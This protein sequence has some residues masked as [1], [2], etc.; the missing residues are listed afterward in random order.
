M[1][2][3][4]REHLVPTFSATSR[5]DVFIINQRANTTFRVK[6]P[7]FS[8]LLGASPQC[9]SVEFMLNRKKEHS[10]K[11]KTPEKEEIILSRF[12]EFDCLA[13]SRACFVCSMELVLCGALCSRIIV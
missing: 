13:V 11:K 10:T 8:A 6:D 9:Y 4:K 5:R 2:W 12:S 3:S 7:I 1:H